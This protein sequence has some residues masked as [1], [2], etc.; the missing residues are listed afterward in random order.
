MRDGELTLQLPQLVRG[1]AALPLGALIFCLIWS[2]LVD[3][4]KATYT[5]CEVAQ[6]APS[7]SAVIGSFSPQNY[8]WRACIALASAPNLLFARM[9]YSYYRERLPLGVATHRLVT[10]N[11]ILNLLETLSLVGLSFVPSAEIFVV[12]EV[13]FITFLGTSILSMVLISFYFHKFCGFQTKNFAERFSVRYKRLLAKATLV[14]AAL[15][16]YFYW[17]HNEYCEP[18]VYSFFGLC[19]YGVVLCN[20]AKVWT[21]SLDFSEHTLRTGPGSD[22]PK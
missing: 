17:R 19:E 5:H 15:A 8:V 3:F 7:I 16:F 4:E 21:A 22:L 18:F 11:F 6:F 1:T 2:L 12:H 10:L 13:F 20:I 14:F 9:H